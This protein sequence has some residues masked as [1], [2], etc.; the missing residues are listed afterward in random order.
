MRRLIGV[1]VVGAM[2]ALTTGCLPAKGT[3]E[4]RTTEVSTSC[5]RGHCKK[6]KLCVREFNDHV[7]CGDV[8]EPVWNNCTVGKS[9]P[10]C[11]DEVSR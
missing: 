6:F 2:L 7:G 5:P 10:K 1:A 3:I 9:W 8:T 4:S 11:K